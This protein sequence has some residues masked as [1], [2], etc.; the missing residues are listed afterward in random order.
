MTEKRTRFRVL[1]TT[2]SLTHQAQIKFQIWWF[3]WTDWQTFRIDKGGMIVLDDKAF[4]Y[5]HSDADTEIDN[6]KQ[7]LA[8]AVKIGLHQSKVIRHEE[9]SL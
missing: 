4:N 1:H 5:L 7:I 9:S 8:N 2:G 3:M 6:A